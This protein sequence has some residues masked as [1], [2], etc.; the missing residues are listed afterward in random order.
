VQAIDRII[1][2]RLLRITDAKTFVES[3]HK[4][5]QKGTGEHGGEF[6]DKDGG[7]GGSSSSAGGSGGS[8]GN[9]GS[10][11][12]PKSSSGHSAVEKRLNLSVSGSEDIGHVRDLAAESKAKKAGK[13]AW[14]AY[15]ENEQPGGHLH[16]VKL[17]KFADGSQGVF[18]PRPKQNWAKFTPEREVAAWEGAK[19]LGIEDLVP[20]VVLREVEGEEGSMADFVEGETAGLIAEEDPEDTAAL[21]YDGSE[22]LARAAMFDYVY[23]NTD[24]HPGNWK[25]VRTKRQRDPTPSMPSQKSKD[26]P[27]KTKMKLL[28][29][30]NIMPSSHIQDFAGGDAK[31]G[32]H[33]Y[34][35]FMDEAIF[36][37]DRAREIREFDEY[38][39]DY[40]ARH[41]GKEPPEE[42]PEPVEE[43]PPPAE[44]VKVCLAKKA[45]LLATTKALPLKAR[46]AQ[47]RRLDRLKKVKQWKDLKFLPSDYV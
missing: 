23:G 21:I 3:E 4:R 33:N 10:G 34:Q 7:G 14:A 30:G 36:R 29:H 38:R 24:R 1:I 20:A 35:M 43:M 9:E 13:K 31:T 28:D 47:E 5:V 42:A 44:L 17:V 46:R 22:D 18:K 39:E 8:A 40:K 12:G 6:T 16:P 41:K 19:I 2:Q 27:K 37:E 25:V 15:R 26:D 11:N 45:D 32:E